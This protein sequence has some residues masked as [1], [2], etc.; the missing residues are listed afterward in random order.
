MNQAAEDRFLALARQYS[1]SKGS[2]ARGP[3]EKEV[4]YRQGE[5]LT[6]AVEESRP[7]RL[8]SR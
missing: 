1:H 6:A 4:G 2:S 8:A 7:Y 5:D 3:W